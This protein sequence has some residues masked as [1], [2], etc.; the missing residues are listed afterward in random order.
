MVPKECDAIMKLNFTGFCGWKYFV[1]DSLQV[2][3][4]HDSLLKHFLS[5]CFKR[6]IKMPFFYFWASMDVHKYHRI[7][8]VVTKQWKENW[9]YANYLNTL[10][11]I[12]WGRKTCN[13]TE[14]SRRESRS[15]TTTKSICFKDE[16]LFDKLLLKYSKQWPRLGFSSHAILLWF[17]IFIF[18]CYGSKFWGQ[19]PQSGI[20]MSI[21]PDQASVRA[22]R[23]LAK[24]Q[25]SPGFSSLCFYFIALECFTVF[26]TVID[27]RSLE[28]F[29]G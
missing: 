24:L 18:S 11:R 1:N 28:C 2:L 10:F 13:P 3:I 9:K 22:D 14:K 27:V 19:N 25:L 21:Q 5:M 7:F 29:A 16:N 8:H 20:S 23:L 6:Q 26:F 12:P 17:L 4:I 15:S